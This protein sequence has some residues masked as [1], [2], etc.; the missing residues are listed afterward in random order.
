M[1]TIALGAITVNLD[2]IRPSMCD[3]LIAT[4]ENELQFAE[5][6]QR[7]RVNINLRKLTTLRDIRG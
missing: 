6:L 7:L 3:D 5:G 2:D 4:Y 1:T